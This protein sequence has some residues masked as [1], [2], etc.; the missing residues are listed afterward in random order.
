MSNKSNEKL[1]LMLNVGKKAEETEEI[2][3]KRYIG[4][5]PVS[6]VALNPTKQELETLYGHEM[7]EPEYKVEGERNGYILEFHVRTISDWKNIGIDAIGRIRFFVS[8]D[9][10]KSKDGLKVRVIDKYGE[11]T[12]VTE[13]QYKAGQKPDTSRV[14]PPYRPA[15]RGEQELY[16]FL[17]CWLN[18]GNGQDSTK[19][20]RDAR[21]WL[22]NSPDILKQCE[23][24]LDWEKVVSGN[25]K[26]IQNLIPKCKDYLLK[27]CWG[28]RT[29]EGKHYQDICNT[30]F[31]K[32]SSNYYE[33][34]ERDISNAKKNGMYENTEFSTQFL[35]EWSVQPTEFTAT[36]NND[37]LNTDIFGNNVNVNNTTSNVTFEPENDD[38]P[39]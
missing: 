22:P 32:N 34:F 38:L 10:L 37:V 31:L 26:E 29:Y 17:K 16:Q 39:F 36:I 13:E 24:E 6:V 15:H 4:I 20:D 11:T 23:I 18:I 1:F 3:F 19:W 9:I 25:I 7:K 2:G 21:K 5:A 28:I 30:T 33:R 8:N 14:I 35:H 12:W 27:T